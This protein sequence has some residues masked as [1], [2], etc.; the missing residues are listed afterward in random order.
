[1]HPLEGDGPVQASP[2]SAAKRDEGGSGFM[3]DDTFFDDEDYQEQVEPI[4]VNFQCEYLTTGQPAKVTIKLSV[5]LFFYLV[6]LH[7]PTQ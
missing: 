7:Y 3:A 5:S 4:K 1:M 2:R 6:G